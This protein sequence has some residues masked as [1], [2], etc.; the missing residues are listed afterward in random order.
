MT[1]ER[2][3]N[4]N[5]QFL[6]KLRVRPQICHAFHVVIFDVL[7]LFWLSKVLSSPANNKKE[8]KWSMEEESF[9]K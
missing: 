3:A 2:L 4:Q 1:I 6:S 7:Q 9:E 5:A 8:L